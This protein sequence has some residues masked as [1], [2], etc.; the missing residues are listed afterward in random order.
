MSTIFEVID[1]LPLPK[2]ETN[3]LQTY[4]IKHN[5]EREI[6]HSALMSPLKTD[7]AK[8]ELLKEFLK[9]LSAD[10]HQ[11]EDAKRFWN[12]LKD[13]NVECGDFLQ[14]P[15]GIN[16]LGDKDETSIIYIRKCYRNLANIAFDK[17]TKKRLRISGN[18]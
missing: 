16:F 14:L 17:K 4:L 9:T 10:E 8:L 1:S 13:K 3:K 2:E 12:A 11:D 7:E 5:Q 18:P 6:L 15:E